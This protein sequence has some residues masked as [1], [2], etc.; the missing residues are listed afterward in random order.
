[1][2]WTI[3][4]GKIQIFWKFECYWEEQSTA[5]KNWAMLRKIEHCWEKLSI[6]EKIEH[7]WVL[8]RKIEHCWAF[9]RK[10]EF[11]WVLLRKT[12]LCWEKLIIAEKNWVFRE[13][14]L[15]IVEKNWVCWKL[16]GKSEFC[17]ILLSKNWALLRKAELAEKSSYPWAWPGRS[18]RWCWARRPLRPLVFH[19]L[20]E[21]CDHGL[22]ISKCRRL[23]RLSHFLL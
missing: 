18:S 11:C 23:P 20:L 1:M 10:T 5:E 17:W 15:K 7:S 21:A 16:L 12:K 8:L 19:K 22:V 13:I 4:G 2:L 14:L 6:A 9:L 3:F